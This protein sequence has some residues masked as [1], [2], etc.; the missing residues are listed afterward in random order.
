[1]SPA[2]YAGMTYT[3]IFTEVEQ[4]VLTRCLLAQRPIVDR[5]ERDVIDGILRD[6]WLPS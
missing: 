2:P 1:M 4:A 3:R 6:G 5:A